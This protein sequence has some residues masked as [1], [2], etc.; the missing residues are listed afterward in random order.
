FKREDAGHRR[1]NCERA[2]R[3]LQSWNLAPLQRELGRY[4]A[5]IGLAGKETEHVDMVC[6]PAVPL[7]HLPRRQTGPRRYIV[8]IGGYAGVV[9]DRQGPRAAGLLAGLE[10]LHYLV[11]MRQQ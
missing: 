2:G 5:H 11:D 6:D 7:D 8:E 10:A 1:R 3:Y 9:A 4:I